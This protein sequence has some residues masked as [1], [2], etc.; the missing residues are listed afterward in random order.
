MP[1]LVCQWLIYAWYVTNLD[2]INS[3]ISD[4]IHGILISDVL[5]C[6]TITYVLS[7]V[8]II[9]VSVVSITGVTSSVSRNDVISDVM[10]VMICLLCQ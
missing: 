8:L 4:V 10:Y 5:S 9:V 1:H 7:G 6:V 2:L 3:S